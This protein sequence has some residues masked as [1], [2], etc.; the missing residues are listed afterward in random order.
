MLTVDGN[1]DPE[2]EPIGQRGK[3]GQARLMAVTRW[4]DTVQV[5]ARLHPPQRPDPSNVGAGF[6]GMTLFSRSTRRS[7]SICENSHCAG[8]AMRYSGLVSTRC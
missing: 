3:A 8:I 1:D 5:V 6:W 2:S 4:R 7:M